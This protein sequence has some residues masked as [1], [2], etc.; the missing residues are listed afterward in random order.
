M[1]RSPQVDEHREQSDPARDAGAGGKLSTIEVAGLDRRQQEYASYL[2]RKSGI[3]FERFRHARLS[4]QVGALLSPFDHLLAVLLGVVAGLAMVLGVWW[5]FLGTAGGVLFGVTLALAIIAGLAFGLLLGMILDL[6]RSFR[7]V[8]DVVD[9]GVVAVREI[10]HESKQVGMSSLRRLSRDELATGVAWVVMVPVIETVLR[11]RFRVRLFSGPVLLVLRRGLRL[12][13]PLRVPSD[14]AAQIAA[15]SERVASAALPEDATGV[16]GYL[17]R[18]RTA[19]LRLARRVQVAVLVP[20]TVA[21]VASLGAIALVAWIL[22][23]LF[24]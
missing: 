7:A 12:V 18:Q 2:L 10:H 11:K 21:A 15:S 22:A 3:D 17:E 9:L 5:A 24:A 6:R 4:D 1:P 19:A 13:L 16:V 20:L 23:G 14:A 8:E